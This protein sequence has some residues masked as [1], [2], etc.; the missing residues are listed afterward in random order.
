[1]FDILYSITIM[2][3]SR[4]LLVIDSHNNGAQNK[5]SA[6]SDDSSVWIWKDLRFPLCMTFA[7][8]SCLRSRTSRVCACTLIDSRDTMAKQYTPKDPKPHM[9]DPSMAQ[10]AKYSIAYL[11]YSDLLSPQH[12]NPWGGRR[13]W[14]PAGWIVEYDLRSWVREGFEWEIRS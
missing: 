9:R 14:Q 3:K 7:P 4:F 8:F 6:V 11:S 10:H 12:P 2:E 13:A 1:M 5:E